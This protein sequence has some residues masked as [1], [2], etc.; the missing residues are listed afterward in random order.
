MRAFTLKITAA[1]LGQPGSATGLF[2][3][4]PMMSAKARGVTMPINA[5][6]NVRKATSPNLPRVVMVSTFPSLLFEFVRRSEFLPGKHTTFHQ[7]LAG[8]RGAFRRDQVG[9][10]G[11]SLTPDQSEKEIIRGRHAKNIHTATTLQGASAVVIHHQILRRF[12]EL[13]P[14]LHFH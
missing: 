10:L 9:Q 13:M 5:R 7:G 2:P 3:S 6:V 11:S 14:R 1:P 12:Q 8:A 4:P